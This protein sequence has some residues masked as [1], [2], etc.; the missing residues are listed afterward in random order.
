MRARWAAWAIMILAA[1]TLAGEGRA[2]DLCAEPVAT[3]SGKVRG[4]SDKE[5]ATCSWLGVPYAAPPVGELRWKAPAPAPAWTGVRDAVKYGDRCL[6]KGTMAAVDMGS[7]VSMSEDCLYL[8]VWRPK[9]SGSFPVMLFIHGGGYTGGSGSTEMYKGDRMAERGDV[10]VVTINYRLNVF[11]FLAHPALRA[12]DAN[13]STGGYGSLDQV[14]A[15]KWVHDNIAGFGGDPGNVTIFGESAGGWSVCTMLATPLNQGMIAR[16]ILESGGCEASAPLEKGYEQAK[17]VAGVFKCAEND[18][19]CLRQ[20]SAKQLLDKGTG[21]QLGGF[22]WVPHYDGY[23]LT[24]SPL[25]MIRSGNYS[26]VPFMAGSNRNEVDVVL[27]FLPQIWRAKPGQ[28]EQRVSEFLGVS[29]DE[30]A[31]IAKVYPLGNYDNMPRRAFGALATDAGLGCPTY[32]GL[33]AAAAQQPDTYYYRFDYHDM[34]YGKHLLAV[35]AMELPFVFNSM[36]R[37]PISALYGRRNI[38]EA[39]MLSRVVQGYWINFAKTGDPNGPG[40][41]VW[42]KFDL[43]SPSV[44]VLDNIVRTEPAGMTERCAYWDS[45]NKDHAPIFE[46]MGGLNKEAEK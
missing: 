37:S 44:Q 22:V 16:A 41:P 35:H 19:A 14:A 45:Y 12:E 46:T 6:Q 34:I 7:G 29:A 20:V 43:A 5:A 10:A 42:P 24:D 27:Y 32:L 11:G 13:Q 15:I 36:D 39:R 26:H 8:N 23:L 28:Y 30:A 1:L 18:V 31:K 40:L 2:Q 3:A 33:A 17:K 9:K 4:M 25:A 21:S 38:E